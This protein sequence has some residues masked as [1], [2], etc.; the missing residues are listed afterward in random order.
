MVILIGL[1]IG[2]IIGLFVNVTIPAGLTPYL[3]VLTLVGIEALT[4]SYNAM[5]RN[6][7]AASKFTIEFLSNIV[8]SGLLTGLGIQL[9]FDFAFVIAFVFAYRI[10][11][12]INFI[13][14]HFYLRYR[15]WR[16]SRRKSRDSDN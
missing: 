14:R 6:E 16:A 5:L 12:N 10:F 2:L 4:S 1:L 9:E 7:F 11:R 3:A 13:S 15:S 8:I